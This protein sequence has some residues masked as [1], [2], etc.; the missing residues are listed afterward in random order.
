VLS[1]PAV[2]AVLLLLPPLGCAAW[3]AAWRRLRPDAARLA[4]LHRSR[5]AQAALKRLHALGADGGAES[6]AVVAD[7]LRQR[8]DLTPEEPTPAEALA[9][10]RRA[11]ISPPVAARVGEFFRAWD[12]LR[13]APGNARDGRQVVAEAENVILALEAESCSSRLS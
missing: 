7:Y 12:A 2:L 11:H 10:L 8:L 5:A 9:Q 3:Y 6:G 4:R 13:F 1:S